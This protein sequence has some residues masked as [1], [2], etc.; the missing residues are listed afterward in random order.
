MWEWMVGQSFGMPIGKGGTDTIITAMV[1]A[2]EAAGGELRLDAPVQSV[3]VEAGAAKAVVLANG[4]RIEATRA[5]IAN[6]HPRV[7]FEELVRGAPPA[8]RQLAKLRPGPAT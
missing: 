3:A 4:E 5:V 8:A 1:R 6:L 7:L 2:I